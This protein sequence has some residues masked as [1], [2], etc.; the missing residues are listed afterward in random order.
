MGRLIGPG[1]CK[2]RGLRDGK[3]EWGDGWTWLA[4]EGMWVGKREELWEKGLFVELCEDPGR[5]PL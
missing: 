5:S 3:S 4:E 2:F 1:G